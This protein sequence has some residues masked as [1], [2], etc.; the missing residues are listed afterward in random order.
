MANEV[1]YNHRWLRILLSGKPHFVIGS[2]ENPYLLR[3]FLI[4]RNR[5]LNVYLHKFMRSDDDRALHDHPWWFVS[6][7]LRGAYDEV[8]PEGVKRREAFSL[9]YRP[10]S[11]RHRVRLLRESL[12]DDGYIRIFAETP[13]WTIIV[14]GSKVRNWGFWCPK[15]FVPWE[16]FT[17]TVNGSSDVSQGCGEFE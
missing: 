5:F 11:W 9:A 17:S 10:A 3:W 8:T 15:G 4:P 6:L 14:T 12:F 13:C 2:K 16:Q 7:L 1:A